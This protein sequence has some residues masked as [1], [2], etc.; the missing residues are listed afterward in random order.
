MVSRSEAAK[1]R[2][3][4]VAVEVLE[5]LGV[6]DFSV[7]EVTRRSG[8]AKTT[9]YRHWPSSGALQLAALDQIIEI[10]A[11][12]NTGSIR[13]DLVAFYEQVAAV[14]Q[15]PGRLQ[16]LLGVVARADRDPE[17]AAIKAELVD[18]RMCPLRT[19]VELAQSRGEVR[20]D[21][22]LDLA[23]DLI[24][25]PFLSRQL[26]SGRVIDKAAVAEIIDSVLVSLVA[27]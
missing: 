11:T 12:P 18:Q 19:I 27:R 24:E 14:F 3:L 22:D 6:N 25:G 7:D 10:T 9:I 17:F 21:L 23:V 13:S 1:Q 26:L 20:A 5:D 2:A 16:I 8:V 15:A 4:R